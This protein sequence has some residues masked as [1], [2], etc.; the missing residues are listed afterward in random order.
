M[1]NRLKTMNQDLENQREETE[2]LSEEL[3]NLEQILAEK[4][5]GNP[6]NAT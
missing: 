5:R 4:F 2:R 3:N 6:W 1:N